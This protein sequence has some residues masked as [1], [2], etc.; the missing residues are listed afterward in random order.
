MSHSNDTIFIESFL[1]ICLKIQ[2]NISMFYAQ[3]YSL[4]ANVNPYRQIN[5]EINNL[6]VMHK[7]HLTGN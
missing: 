2:D 5:T 6:Q 4:L 3:N 7:G 1:E